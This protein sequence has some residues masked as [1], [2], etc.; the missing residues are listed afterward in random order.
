MAQKVQGRRNRQESV[1]GPQK[2]G[3]GRDDRVGKGRKVCRR[4]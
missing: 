4:Q 2:K 3:G 1:E